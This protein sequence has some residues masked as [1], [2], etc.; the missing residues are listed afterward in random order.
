[1]TSFCRPGRDRFQVGLRLSRARYSGV[2]AS[3]VNVFRHDGPSVPRRSLGS[4]GEEIV[5]PM[6]GRVD[7]PRWHAAFPQLLANG[8]LLAISSP[9]QRSRSALAAHAAASR[10]RGVLV[11]SHRDRRSCCRRGS[12]TLDG[13]ARRRYDHRGR[14]LARGQVSQPEAVADVI[15]QAVE[16]A[17]VVAVR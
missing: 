7:G 3:G 12:D 10:R 11:G 1:V 5:G 2:L 13:A 14:R 9:C 17:S 4:T 16:A 6:N 15:A 8:G